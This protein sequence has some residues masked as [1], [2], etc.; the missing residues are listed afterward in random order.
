MPSLQKI[1]NRFLWLGCCIF[2][3]IYL[4][5][6]FLPTLDLCSPYWPPVW[7]L[8]LNRVEILFLVIETKV[9][10][11]ISLRSHILST[12]VSEKYWERFVKFLKGKV[13]CYR[14]STKCLTIISHL[15]AEKQIC[16]LLW[17]LY[18]L[19]RLNLKELYMVFFIWHKEYCDAIIT[20][21]DFVN[22]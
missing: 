16:S 21:A 1:N 10:G 19:G 20:M 7:L 8:K 12:N 4:P 9:W 5:F 18:E 22:M 2:K 11:A 14:S 6:H 3:M 15:S 13:W 17:L